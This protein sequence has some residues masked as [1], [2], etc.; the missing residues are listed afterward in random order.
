MKKKKK[1]RKKERKKRWGRQHVYFAAN[2]WGSRKKGEE[3]KAGKGKDTFRF[4]G[5]CGPSRHRRKKKEVLGEKKR[6]RRN[7]DRT[8]YVS[9]HR[10]LSKPC[11]PNTDKR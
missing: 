3:E 8:R 5:H 9:P 4:L 2:P 1:R 6:R 10:T 7:T 11:L